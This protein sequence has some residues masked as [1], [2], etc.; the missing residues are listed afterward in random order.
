M[1]F[2]QCHLLVNHVWK[3]NKDIKYIKYY[4]INMILDCFI[5]YVDVLIRVIIKWV[6]IN[7]M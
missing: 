7:I 2:Q 5:H 4:L 6:K 3:L 1:I